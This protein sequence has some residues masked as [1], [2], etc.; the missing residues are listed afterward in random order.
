[1]RIVWSQRGRAGVSGRWIGL[2]PRLSNELLAGLLTASAST[3]AGAPADLF[4]EIYRTGQPLEQSFKTIVANL[5][6]TTT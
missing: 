3:L 6:E 1:M 4:D 2:P 5:T